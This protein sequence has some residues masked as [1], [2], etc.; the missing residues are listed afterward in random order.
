[1]IFETV[2]TV[3]ESQI[4]LGRHNDKLMLRRLGIYY[5]T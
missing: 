3:T 2:G 4:S 5:L 1:M